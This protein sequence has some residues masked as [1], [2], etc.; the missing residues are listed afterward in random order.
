MVFVVLV[1]VMA[2]TFCVGAD[3]VLRMGRVIAAEVVE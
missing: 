1:V 3:A 2:L